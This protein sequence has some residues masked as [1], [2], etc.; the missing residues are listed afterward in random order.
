M[1]NLLLVGVV[2]CALL[3]LSCEPESTIGAI[4]DVNEAMSDP[5]SSVQL[6]AENLQELVG[7]SIIL[8]SAIKGFPY[9]KAILGA[10]AIV[11]AVL[12]VILG[13]RK[14]TTTKALKEVV[15]GGEILKKEI[16]RKGNVD[17]KDFKDAH[18]TQNEETVEIV[19][20]IRHKVT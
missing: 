13:W 8:V 10:L 14:H 16:V 7:T 5:N 11:Q 2:L 4:N 18:N 12:T 20:K 6:T 19:N 15:R 1:K 3:V 17:M 9:A